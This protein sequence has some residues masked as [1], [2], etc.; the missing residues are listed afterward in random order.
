[1]ADWS[2]RFEDTITLP[3]GRTLSTLRDAGDYITGLPKAEQRLE[4]WQTAIECLTGAAE[5]RDYMMHARIGLLRALNRHVERAF[6]PDRK[7]T[8]WAKRK[9]KRDQ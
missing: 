8:H 1:M 7:D 3:D 2:R 5:D 4:E 9:L 6:K